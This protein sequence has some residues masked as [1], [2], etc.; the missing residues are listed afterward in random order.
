MPVV[1]LLPCNLADI[2]DEHPA[3]PWLKGKGEGIAQAERPD[4][5]V[6]AGRREV[7]R[8]VGRDAAIGIDAQHLAQKIGK[9]LRVRPVRIL[10]DR[11]VDAVG[12]SGRAACGWSRSTD[13]SN[14][15]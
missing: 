14:P 5:A 15:G 10:A 2:I 12:R 3:G 4:R 9:R 13:C 6:V 11:D 1:D 7:E 8:V